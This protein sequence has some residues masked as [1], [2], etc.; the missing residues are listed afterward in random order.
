MFVWPT[1]SSPREICAALE[2]PSIAFARDEDGEAQSAIVKAAVE[3]VAVAVV[4]AL[5]VLVDGP[6]AAQGAGRG[7]RGGRG[8]RR[9]ERLQVTS[10][11]RR[12]L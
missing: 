6:I 2:V 12:R 8:T 4:V 10:G 11:S 7:G 5:L 1:I 3:V 9:R